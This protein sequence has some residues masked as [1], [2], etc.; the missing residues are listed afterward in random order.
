MSQMNHHVEHRDR[1]VLRPDPALDSTCVQ[2]YAPGH[3]AKCGGDMRYKLA[4]TYVAFDPTGTELLVNMGGE[5]VY[6]FDVN[7][8]KET[9]VQLLQCPDGLFTKSRKSL[10]DDCVC[11]VC[12]YCLIY[13]FPNTFYLRI[14]S[15]LDLISA[16]L[17][18]L[19]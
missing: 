13:A 9:S 19:I 2:Y 12:V 15:Q 3:L 18:Y 6:L 5:Q 4:A 7:G 14:P 10:E 17:H 16:F 1:T 8:A 11:G